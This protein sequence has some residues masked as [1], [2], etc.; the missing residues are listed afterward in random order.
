MVT[1]ACN[2]IG[3]PI[4][5]KTLGNDHV[6]TI[7]VVILVAVGD[8]GLIAVD[9]VVDAIDAVV[10]GLDGLEL[11]PMFGRLVSA[12]GK[13]SHLECRLILKIGKAGLVTHGGRIVGLAGERIDGAATG[14]GCRANGL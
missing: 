11:F 2:L 5:L 7:T 10:K 14:K 6:A 3:H 4:M 1:D 8:Y 13:K 9:P 12:G